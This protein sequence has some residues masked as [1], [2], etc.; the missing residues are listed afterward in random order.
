MTKIHLSFCF[1]QFILG[2]IELC[3]SGIDPKQFRHNS[4]EQVDS[5]R[6]VNK[7]NYH[8]QKYIGLVKYNHSFALGLKLDCFTFQGQYSCS[9]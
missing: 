5:R 9:P 3:E 1:S 7:L 4:L 2:C 8:T 6:L